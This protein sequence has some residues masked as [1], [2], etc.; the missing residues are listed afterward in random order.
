MQVDLLQSRNNGRIDQITQTS[1]SDKLNFNVSANM[2]T[3]TY[4]VFSKKKV[5]LVDKWTSTEDIGIKYV[6]WYFSHVRVVDYKIESRCEE[7]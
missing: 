3:Q 7:E 4:S 6:N 2:V 1:Y 5:D